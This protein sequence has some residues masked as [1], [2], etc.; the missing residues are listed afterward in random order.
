MKQEKKEKKEKGTEKVKAPVHQRKKKEKKQATGEKTREKLKKLQD[1]VVASLE[2]ASEG[3]PERVKKENKKESKK[4]VKNTKNSKKFDNLARYGTV[5]SIVRDENARVRVIPLGGLNE[6]GKNITVIECGDDIIVIDCGF[7]FPDEEMLGVDLVL[8][9]F[10]YLRENADKVR[11]IVLTHGHEDHIGGLP[12]ALNYATADV[13]LCPVKSYDSAAFN[14]FA[15][16]GFVY[17]FHFN[18]P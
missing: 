14:S 8:P 4:S 3:K 16:L 10:T 9:D 2:K 5:S 15:K 6:I 7:A 12:G 1:E 17:Y 11:A 13:V 18:I